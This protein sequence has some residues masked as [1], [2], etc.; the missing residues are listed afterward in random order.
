VPEP[1]IRE[2]IKTKE[3]YVNKPTKVDTRQLVTIL[4]K[5]FKPVM[6]ETFERRKTSC[7]NKL[8]GLLSDQESVIRTAIIRS[9][10]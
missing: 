5:K 2:V 4:M 6:D 9:T 7:I 8:K 3:V 1:I 10:E